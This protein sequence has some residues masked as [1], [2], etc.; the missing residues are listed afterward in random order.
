ME[1]FPAAEKT[2]E[3]PVKK[4]FTLIELLMVIA[5]IAILASMLLPALNK[6]RQQAYTI[7][8]LNTQKQ[9][10]LWLT[11]YASDYKE[12]SVGTYRGFV[13]NP[14]GNNDADKAMWVEFF[15]PVTKVCVTPY[16]KNMKKTLHCPT[17]ANA[18]DS[19][20]NKTTGGSGYMGYY[21]INQHLRRDYNRKAYNWITSNGYAFFKPS[22][23]KLP[24]RAMW[25]M[26]TSRYSDDHFQFWHGN[27]ARLLFVDLVVRPLYL[28]EIYNKVSQTTALDYY[29]ASGSPNWTGYPN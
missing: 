22:T 9:I 14:S 20:V 24:S 10:G 19:Y 8:C 28:R 16:I 26:C 18:T 7:Q 17:A 23:V 25:V 29:P 3:V 27:S 5:I 13:N 6:A 1:K 4:S 2:K 15:A 11:S 21:S 12:W